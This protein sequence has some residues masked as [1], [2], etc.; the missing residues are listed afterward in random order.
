MG[1]FLH[2]TLWGQT[3]YLPGGR[4]MVHS[5]LPGGSPGSPNPDPGSERP[6]GCK[7]SW[8]LSQSS[9]RLC[10][11]PPPH[12]QNWPIPAG[13]VPA[14]VTRRVLGLNPPGGRGGGRLPLFISTGHCRRRVGVA[15]EGAGPGPTLQS[16]TKGRC[17]PRRKVRAAAEA[18][19]GWRGGR[20]HPAPGVGQVG[21]EPGCPAVP[22]LQRSC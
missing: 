18:P 10:A 22:P 12:F 19:G 14:Q 20:S 21:A 15:G 16:R 6:Q 1:S 9:L 13:L 5:V 2:S 17:V 7:R 11:L 8:R 4:A 3:S